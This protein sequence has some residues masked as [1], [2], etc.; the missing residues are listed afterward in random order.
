[1]KGASPDLRPAHR[2]SSRYQHIPFPAA[3]PVGE[4]A[5]VRQ[6]IKSQPSALSA[7]LCN[8]QPSRTAYAVHCIALCSE[9]QISVVALVLEAT[10]EHFLE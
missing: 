7:P 4:Q 2:T 10:A 5:R 1:M 9:K 3:I 8:V 6:Q